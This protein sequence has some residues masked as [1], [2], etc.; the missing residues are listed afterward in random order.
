MSV[1]SLNIVHNKLIRI[2]LE[3][4]RVDHLQVDVL[5]AL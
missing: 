1:L 5:T 3:K 4:V 2:P